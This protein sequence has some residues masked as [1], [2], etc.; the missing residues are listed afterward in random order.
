LSVARSSSPA[1]SRLWHTTDQR[2][3]G[4]AIEVGHLGHGYRLRIHPCFRAIL[5][6]WECGVREQTDEAG[7]R[8]ASASRPSRRLGPLTSQIRPLVQG[9]SLSPGSRSWGR[10]SISVLLMRDSWSC[11]SRR[12][13]SL[14]SPFSRRRPSGVPFHVMDRIELP[15]VFAT[16][17]L[18]GLS[19]L[20]ALMGA[21]FCSLAELLA[22]IPARGGSDGREAK[23]HGRP[24]LRPG[25]RAAPFAR[26]MVAA[27]ICEDGA[28]PFTR[29]SRGG[30]VRHGPE[31]VRDATGDRGPAGGGPRSR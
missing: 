31:R 1:M 14:S 25:A 21:A 28:D 10:A 2:F 9:D 19:G 29:D 16:V 6:R 17:G 7:P 3:L 22:L 12:W 30:E 11:R 26:A 13:E 23:R 4:G 27:V 8:R 24:V 18:V 15:L 20:A 5:R